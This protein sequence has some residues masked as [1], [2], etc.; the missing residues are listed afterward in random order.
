MGVVSL[1][2]C[3]CAALQKLTCVSKTCL[4]GDRCNHKVQQEKNKIE[5]ARILG[6]VSEEIILELPRLEYVMETVKYLEY[7]RF[8][9]WILTGCSPFC[10]LCVN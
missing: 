9:L 4:E 1:G 10:P 5:N 8:D 6:R 2:I 3:V 7:Y